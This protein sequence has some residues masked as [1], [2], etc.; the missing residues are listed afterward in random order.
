MAIVVWCESKYIFEE[1]KKQS[2]KS[3]VIEN[4]AK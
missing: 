2:F 1:K 3:E 4:A